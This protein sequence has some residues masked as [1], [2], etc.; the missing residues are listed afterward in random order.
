MSKKMFPAVDSVDV[1][2]IP[3]YTGN[4]IRRIADAL[5]RIS[6]LLE[7]KDFSSCPASGPYL[8]NE[9]PSGTSPA[10]ANEAMTVSEAAKTLRISLPKMYELVHDGKV[11]SLTVGRKILVS[12]SSL[13]NLL[14]EGK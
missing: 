10:G 4:E 3:D 2:A 5:E 9:I 6:L 12:R 13:M 14:K 8:E 7:H 1:Q 11:H